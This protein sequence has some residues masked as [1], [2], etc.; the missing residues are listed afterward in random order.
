[1]QLDSTKEEFGIPG[2]VR[3]N[4]GKH[5]KYNTRIENTF[6]CPGNI[7]IT[8]GEVQKIADPEKHYLIDNFLLDIE[9]K[10]IS[11]YDEKYADAFVEGLKDI[12]KISIVKDKKSGDGRK[13]IT[14]QREGQE[15]PIVITIDKDDKIVG[16]KNHELREVGDGFFKYSAGL[17]ELDIPNVEI[18]GND[19]CPKLASEEL[20]MPKLKK[21]GDRCCTNAK[22]L[23]TLYLQELEEAGND[24][25]KNVRF[26]EKFSL[27]NLKKAGKAFFQQMQNVK[28]AEFPSL[29]ELGDD[30]LVLG[31]RLKDISAP[32]LKK[33]GNRFLGSSK[34]TT[35]YLPEL[36]EAGEN[37][38]CT[39]RMLEQI[40]L[41]KVKRVGQSFAANNYCL[42]SVRMPNLESADEGFI[43]NHG[44]EIIEFETPKISRLKW[45]FSENRRVVSVINKAKR[46]QRLSRKDI[47]RLDK[48]AELLPDE[49]KETE[50][51]IEETTI[52]RNKETLINI[53]DNVI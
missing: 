24:C 7:V 43:E 29:T 15:E 3:A 52:E 8:N 36:E 2:Y 45:F 1:M 5:Y 38:C 21:M 10:T 30:S 32:K 17:E 44:E 33:V 40:D 51:I 41:P 9:K 42:K 35:I 4:D 13:H 46:A 18:V 39:G 47:T 20:S 49:V 53:E 16:Y 25:F 22:N 27:A 50:K 34:L 28:T 11:V 37:F 12:Q 26:L 14:I 23:K 31:N 6:Y 19:F 48:Q